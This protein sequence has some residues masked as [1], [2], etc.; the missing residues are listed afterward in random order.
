MKAVSSQGVVERFISVHYYLCSSISKS[1]SSSSSSSSSDIDI[2]TVSHF[3]LLD[4]QPSVAKRKG[5]HHCLDQEYAEMDAKLGGG[6]PL[7]SRYQWMDTV[8]YLNLI[9]IKF[10]LSPD[11]NFEV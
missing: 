9:N 1:S 8:W 3:T 2:K 4:K 11:S 7:K 5:V 6:I 10:V